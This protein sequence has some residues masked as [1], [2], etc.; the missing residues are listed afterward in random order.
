MVELSDKETGRILGS[1]TDDQLQ[2]LI[3]Q[4]EEE[5]DGD[6]DYYID[7]AS[8]EMLADRSIDPQL[9]TLLR[10]ALGSRE[11]MEIEWKR[12]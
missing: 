1:I 11:G 9:L 8:L 2:F 10:N 12:K 4:F 7:A 6:T 5:S 3:D